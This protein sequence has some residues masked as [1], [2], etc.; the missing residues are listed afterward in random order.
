MT[1]FVYIITK[2]INPENNVFSKNFD[3]TDKVNAMIKL[4]F[5]IFITDN[6]SINKSKHKFFFENL[7]NPFLRCNKNEFIEYFYKIQKIYWGFSKL[8]NSYKHKKAKIVSNT[9]MNLNEINICDKNIIPIY[10]EKNIYLFNIN[11]LIKIINTS[12]TNAYHFISDPLPSKN[13][14]NNIPFN[15]STLYNIYFYIKFKTNNYC[16]LITKFFESNF[17][18]TLF[19]KNN[20]YLLREYAINNYVKNSPKNIICNDI[21]RMINDYNKRI[22]N[23]NNYL[24]IHKEFPKDKLIQIFKPYLFLLFRSS[25][26]LVPEIKEASYNYLIFKLNIFHKFNPKFGRKIAVIGLKYSKNLKKKPYIK[27]YKY[28]ELHINFNIEKTNFMTNHMFINNYD[29]YNNYYE[30]TN[31]YHNE[32]N[33]QQYNSN[34]INNSSFEDYNYDDDDDDDDD[35]TTINNNNDDNN[36]NDNN[37]NNDNDSDYDDYNENDINLDNIMNINNDEESYQTSN[38]NSDEADSIS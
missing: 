21:H 28:N 10:Q 29:L 4:L 22:I 25:F 12:L 33:T 26:C 13:P 6:R 31:E 35:D 36:Y 17:N 2:I 3:N 1:A 8:L 24:L 34:L 14:Y 15:K 16:E 23:K 9:D 27:H 32:N 38:Y 5:N 30:T 20:M 37:D 7:K 19:L 18:I 11:D